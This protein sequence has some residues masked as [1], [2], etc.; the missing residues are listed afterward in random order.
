MIGIALACLI[1]DMCPECTNEY[2]N[3]ENRRFHAQ[4]I[5]CHFCGPHA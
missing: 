1:L 3:P 5:A 2:Q 4:P